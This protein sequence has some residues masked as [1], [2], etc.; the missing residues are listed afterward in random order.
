MILSM[1]RVRA[2]F[3]KDWK[4]AVKSPNLYVCLFVPIFSALLWRQLDTGQSAIYYYTYVI[5]LACI[6]PGIFNQSAMI[7][8]EKEKNTLRCLL[9]S[10]TRI[11]EI[12]LGKSLL[13]A[14][15]IILAGIGAT[16][17]VPYEVTSYIYFS[18]ALLLCMTIFIAIGTIIGLVVSSI[19]QS[20]G[21]SILFTTFVGNSLALKLLFT[22][23]W[24]I[25]CLEYLPHE[26]FAL[27]LVAMSEGTRFHDLASYFGILTA[28]LVITVGLA[29]LIYK[30]NGFDK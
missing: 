1:K 2:I 4:E 30:K 6:V 8:E 29:V 13:T 16:F 21:L 24:F 20:L 17:I 19:Q 28:W 26:Q 9:L 10:P 14:I 15:I 3:I 18:L 25:K 5:S 12:F 11:I 27:L 22:Q 7:A 23:E